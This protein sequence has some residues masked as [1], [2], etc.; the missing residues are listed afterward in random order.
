MDVEE[1]YCRYAAGERDFSGVDLTRADL[2]IAKL[3]YSEHLKPGLNDLSGINLCSANLT[4]ANL[5]LVNLCGANLRSANLTLAELS[6]T[7]LTAANMQ[8]AILECAQVGCHLID[9]DLRE[10]NLFCTG[11]AY[12]KLTRVNL[13]GARFQVHVDGYLVLRDTIMPDGSI[14]NEVYE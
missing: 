8:K 12:A 11:F 13:M 6:C 7:I 4:R 5:S 2:N 3:K 10:A 1:L 9:V 14:K